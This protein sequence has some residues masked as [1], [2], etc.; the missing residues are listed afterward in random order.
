MQRILWI[1]SLELLLLAPVLS[2]LTQYTSYLTSKLKYSSA[3]ER[4]N[5]ALENAY[6][7]RSPP[8]A[9][10]YCS[11]RYM[12][13]SVPGYESLYPIRFLEE[14]TNTCSG[15]EPGK[16]ASAVAHTSILWKSEYP[17][18][19]DGKKLHLDRALLQLKNILFLKVSSF[20]VPYNDLYELYRITKPELL[21][22]EN[23]EMGKFDQTILTEVSYNFTGLWLKN[24]NFSYVN[25]HLLPSPVKLLIIEQPDIDV[26]PMN[27]ALFR[28]LT[29][30]K[31]S[32][33]SLF[34]RQLELLPRNLEI[35][36][37]QDTSL[38][39]TGNIE[40]KGN[41]LLE[42]VQINRIRSFR[43]FSSTQ[44]PSVLKALDLS[45]N[46]LTSVELGDVAKGLLFLDLSHN[47]LEQ[48]DLLN[49]LVSVE[50]VDLSHNWITHMFF[51]ETSR[52][53]RFLD[54]RGN[55]MQRISYTPDFL[56]PTDTLFG[57]YVDD[58]SW[59]CGWLMDFKHS[60]K[61]Y[62]RLV[63]SYNYSDVNVNGLPCVLSP[64][65]QVQ[66]GLGEV[67]L[68][69]KYATPVLILLLLSV[70][71][72]T[73]AAVL[74]HRQRNQIH[75]QL[76]NHKCPVRTR[77][78]P[79]V[80]EEADVA[81]YSSLY[82]SQLTGSRKYEEPTFGNGVLSSRSPMP[83]PESYDEVR[84][85][86]QLDS[87]TLRFRPSTSPEAQLRLPTSFESQQQWC[88]DPDLQ[89]DRTILNEV[90]NK[91][92]IQS[93]VPIVRQWKYEDQATDT[94]AT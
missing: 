3:L 45:E 10:G 23:N 82:G 65:S 16:N 79:R 89:T 14:T 41:L 51:D 24:N 55:R 50:Q 71:V 66:E 83:I 28:Q 18:D 26:G 53:L 49:S 7:R 17:E 22:L 21:M 5:Q 42:G 84:P 91:P 57:A 27:F 29:Y 77:P 43:T 90:V 73:A 61:L 2:Q 62:E 40:L 8:Q 35:L 48:F 39:G 33:K 70:M 30:F 1:I 4:M 80:P 58:N 38:I 34:P 75:Q 94:D 13:M 74:C 72:A 86:L 85:E 63:H 36:T 78:L 69:S 76:L 93:Y 46:S 11:V 59:D 44:L 31:V 67:T 60:P 25:T 19:T 12:A 92:V 87:P 15:W 47:E 52:T 9:E 6:N 37:V 56:W 20:H 32:I 81:H 64:S 88:K 68:L 54:L